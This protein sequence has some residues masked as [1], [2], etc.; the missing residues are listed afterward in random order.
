MIRLRYALF[1]IILLFFAYAISFSSL[2][3]VTEYSI[4]FHL[5][6]SEQRM[7]V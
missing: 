3:G 7:Q 1:S 4:Q 2:P 6:L 5:T